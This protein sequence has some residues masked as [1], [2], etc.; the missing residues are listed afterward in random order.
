M[1]RY[2]QEN[3]LISKCQ[4]VFLPGRSTH[5]AIFQFAKHLYGSMNNNK[6]IGSVFLD[7]AKAFNCI[8]HTVLYLK[9]YN[10][11]FSPKVINWFKSYL[12]RYQ[13]VK[14]NDIESTMIP[15]VD[16]IAQGTVL[17]PLV[18]IFYINNVITTLNHVNISMFADDC[19]LYISGNNWPAIYD[20][21]QNDVNAFVS[22]INENALVLNVSKT[23]TVIFGNRHKLSKIKNPRPISICNR[24]VE[25]V[26]KY[27]YL[28][29]T[30]D[31]DMNLDSLYKD[32][33]KKVNNKIYNLRKLRRYVNFRISVNI[34]KQTILPILDFGGFMMLSMSIKN[35][36]LTY[37]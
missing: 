7:I 33:V 2:L 19:V 34:Y 16:G 22:W 15:V 24:N 27:M 35:A 17:G 31:C 14:L 11:G 23:K 18:F 3:N 9:M 32:V 29:V 21:L 4:Y 5:Q 30:L 28:G 10:A 25:F 26:K 20:K 1:L 12:S 36:G 6:I 13:T 37:R 8:S